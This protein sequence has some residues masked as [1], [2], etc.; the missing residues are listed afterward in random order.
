MRCC[1]SSDWFLL[2]YSVVVKSVS[3]P[4]LTQALTLERPGE[5][6]V[7]PSSVGSWILHR[8]E[9]TIDFLHLHSEKR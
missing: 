1:V 2:N 4:L 3:L 7:K 6:Q 5:S 8:E 9:Q